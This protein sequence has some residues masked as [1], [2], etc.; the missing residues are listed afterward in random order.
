MDVGESAIG[1]GIILKLRI[2]SGKFMGPNWGWDNVVTERSKMYICRLFIMS[3]IILISN[4]DRKEQV[5]ERQHN[6]GQIWL[7]AFAPLGA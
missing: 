5:E 7:Q 2:I 3:Y 1:T 6:R 4:D